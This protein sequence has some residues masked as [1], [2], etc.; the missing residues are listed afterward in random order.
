MPYPNY[1]R[2]MDAQYVDVTGI[3]IDRWDELNVGGMERPCFYFKVLNDSYTDVFISW[4]ADDDHWFVPS[5]S[6]SAI[7]MQLNCS[8]P[9]LVSKVKNGQKLYVRGNPDIKFGG[10]IVFTGYY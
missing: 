5:Q 1:V 10:V 9:S 7:N 6:K 8:L 2:V 4:N 3:A